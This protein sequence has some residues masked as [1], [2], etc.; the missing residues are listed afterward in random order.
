MATTKNYLIEL[1][2]GGRQ[3]K[4][5]GLEVKTGTF[6]ISAMSYSDQVLAD[7]EAGEGKQFTFGVGD[8]INLEEIF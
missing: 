5:R 8:T 2:P 4:M 6:V 1:G 3:I 7:I